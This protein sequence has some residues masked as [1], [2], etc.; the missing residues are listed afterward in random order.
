MEKV[1][2]HSLD[3]T[4]YIAEKTLSFTGREWVFQAINTWLSNPDGSPIFLLLGEPGSGKT[5]I[6]SRLVQ[7]SQGSVSPPLSPAIF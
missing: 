3:F 2:T 6:A 7:F 4:S 1:T 5:A